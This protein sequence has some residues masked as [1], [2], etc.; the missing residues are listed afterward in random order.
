LN[1]IGGVLAQD[2]VGVDCISLP[3]LHLDNYMPDSNDLITKVFDNWLLRVRERV[4]AS[5]LE[6]ALRRVAKNNQLTDQSALLE[7]L[8]SDTKP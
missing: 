7:A 1:F 5:K 6:E 2:V 4:P 3:W 8:K